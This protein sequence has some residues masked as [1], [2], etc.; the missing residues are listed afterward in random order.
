MNDVEFTEADRRWMARALSLAKQAEAI[1]E[2][3]VGAVLVRDGELLGEGFNQPI[4]NSDPTAHAELI[5]LRAACKKEGNYRLPG[6]TLYVTLEPCTMCAG[7]LVHA[8]LQEVVFAAKEPKA[9]AL[10]STQDFFSSPQLN[11]LV[12]CRHGLEAESAGNMLSQ[13]FKRR[14]EE[15]KRSKRSDSNIS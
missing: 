14:R 5:A 9:G 10:V 2:V 15:R 1:G 6:A 12:A 3:P 4:T 7:A 13:F 8:R 11:H